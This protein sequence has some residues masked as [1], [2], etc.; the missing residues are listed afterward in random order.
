L[1]AL[2]GLAGAARPGAER[3]LTV[4]GAVRSGIPGVLAVGAGA[5]AADLLV[6][7]ILGGFLVGQ[8]RALAHPPPALLAAG[9]VTGLVFVIFGWRLMEE[10]AAGALHR[11]RSGD[12]VRTWSRNPFL[13]RVAAALLSPGRQTLWWL[14]GVGV[15][16]GPARDGLPGIAA[17]AAG[18]LAGGLSFGILVA[19]GLSR[20][21]SEWAVSDRRFR[22][23][24][25]LTGLL[26][27]VVGFHVGEQALANSRLAEIA[28]RIV[29]TVFG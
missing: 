20:P 6:V 4:R 18:L 16:L 23:L 25:T 27:A 14:A 8:S 29:G 3:T 2:I 19:R 10:K 17:F 13:D 21:G 24:T 11:E 1:G 9:I 7:A 26:I 28:L 5:L 15:L 22:I 12:H